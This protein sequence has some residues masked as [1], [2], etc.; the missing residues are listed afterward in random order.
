M[1]LPTTDYHSPN[2][3]SLDDYTDQIGSTTTTEYSGAV[4]MPLL[5]SPASEHSSQSPTDHQQALGSGTNATIES[6]PSYDSFSTGATPTT[7]DHQPKPSQNAGMLKQDKINVRPEQTDDDS[8]IESSIPSTY[9]AEQAIEHYGFGTFQIFLLLL[10]GTVWM[11]D[12]ME[13][14][15]LSFLMPTIKKEWNLSSFQSSAIGSVAFF[16]MIF[17]AYFWGFV[18]DRVGRK[19]AIAGMLVFTLV[20]G[21]ASSL[22]PNFWFLLVFRGLVGFGVAGSCVAFSLFSEFLPQKNRGVY[23]L[24]IEVFWTIGV[25][26][27]AL[28]A[29]VTLYESDTYHPFRAI[30]NWRVFL[31]CTNIPMILVL[32][33]VPFLP[34]SHRFL[35]IRDKRGKVEKIYKRVAF[36]NQKEL[37]DGSPTCRKVNT[38]RFTDFFKKGLRSTMATLIVLWICAAGV[39]YGVVV[40]TPEYFGAKTE[41]QHDGRAGTGLYVET[42]ITSAAEL[43]GLLFSSLLINSVGRKK[44]LFITYALTATGVALLTLPANRALLTVFAVVTRGMAMGASCS[45]WVLSTEI[46]PTSVR[47]S[48]IGLASSASRVAG[49]LTPFISSLLF[50]VNPLIPIV[51]Y[52]IV[53]S[54][55]ALF[56]LMIPYETKGKALLDTVEESTSAKNTSLPSDGVSVIGRV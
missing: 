5:A 26:F 31:F 24:I 10:C 37:L 25:I 40:L 28:L 41:G 29:W 48:G 44:T 49:A 1:T 27:E 15:L 51:I 8:D 16:G 12:A 3:E 20:F 47:S 55:G 4:E 39:Y 9:T 7:T 50:E 22:S 53:G 21:V 17:G 35:L 56:S 38:G 14:I 2:G 19:V 23:L 42:L 54:I 13:I 11:V 36:W 6:P 32:A 18:S 45:V 33:F 43:P 52:V 34:E 30:G 46:L